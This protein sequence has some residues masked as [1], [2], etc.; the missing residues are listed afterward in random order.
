MDK[1]ELEK[2]RIYAYRDP[3]MGK[4]AEVDGSPFI[5]MMNP[6]TYSIETKMEFND[7][8]GQGTSGNEPA[9][10]LKNPEEMSF[11]FLFDN[12]GIIDKAPREDI[13]E[14]LDKFKELLMGYDGETHE[15]KF[16][17]LAWG[18]LVFKGRCTG[19]LVNYKLF[20]A[21]GSPMRA[22]CKV[23]LK[24]FIQD[25]ERVA[26]EN[27]QSPDLTHVRVVKAGDSL[28]LMCFVIYG[29]ARHYIEVARF[30]GLTNLRRL[31][32]GTELLFPPLDNSTSRERAS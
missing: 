28:P 22:V 24:A 13:S 11:E 20:N 1:G 31:V 15:P 8:Q 25:D 9:F 27:A 5:A 18:T 30:N 26:E 3:A 23:T 12:T 32:P 21:D 10:Q 14:E 2:M 16:F 17:K 4:D 29:D 6:E 7:E 19:L